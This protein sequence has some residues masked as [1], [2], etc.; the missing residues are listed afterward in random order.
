MNRQTNLSVH[1]LSLYLPKDLTTIVWDYCCGF[2]NFWKTI[3]F[4]RCLVDIEE[5]SRSDDTC[6]SY[7]ARTF[8]IDSFI[9]NTCGYNCS[10]N[11]PFYVPNS[12]LL[13][14]NHQNEPLKNIIYEALGVYFFEYDMTFE[15][16]GTTNKKRFIHSTKIPRHGYFAIHDIVYDYTGLF[17]AFVLKN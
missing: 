16:Y 12:S 15:E 4:G 2:T 5:L 8:Y 10:K 17:Y 6:C 11:Y 3:F 14:F 7:F 13:A 1:P 9:V